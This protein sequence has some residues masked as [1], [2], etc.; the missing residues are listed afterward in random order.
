MCSTVAVATSMLATHY[1][2]LTSAH[3]E[4]TVAERLRNTGLIIFDGLAGRRSVLAFATRIMAMTP[5]RDSDSDG[6]TTIRDIP[7]K[8]GRAGYAG[9]GRGELL[10]H[11]EGSSLPEPPRLMLLACQR[12]ADQGGEC[13]LADGRAVHADLSTSWHEAAVMLS[14]PC[15]AFFGAGDGHCT[16]VF[17]VHPGGRVTLRLRQ[18]E[19]ARWSPLV[20]PHLPRLAE[21][22]IRHQVRLPLTPGQ[23]YLLD[24]YRWLHARTQFTG[25]RCCLRALGEPRTC[26][27]DGF[28][29]SP[30]AALVPVTTEAA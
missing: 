6:L 2:D 23:G 26:L 18:D 29:I 4:A 5:H 25:D 24:N 7:G 16:Q 27:A 1:V 22:I 8:C 17:T 12:P 28:A 13:L 11:T 9:L 10:A 20:A 15:T 30:A 21:V 14:R 3:A 19:L